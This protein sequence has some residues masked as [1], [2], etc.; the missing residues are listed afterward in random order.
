MAAGCLPGHSAVCTLVLP[1][2]GGP[3]RHAALE[4]LGRRLCLRDSRAGTALNDHPID[5]AR[6][7]PIS[8]Q[9]RVRIGRRRF[10]ARRLAAR[11]PSSLASAWSL[12]A[13]SRGAHS[14]S[15]T[16]RRGG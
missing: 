6:P 5:P 1:D 10:R 15:A 3:R 13:V 11:V 4:E 9:D 14:T 7:A 2:P 12:G 8:E 16:E